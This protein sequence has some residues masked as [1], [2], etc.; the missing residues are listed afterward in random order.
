MMVWLSDLCGGKFPIGISSQ[1]EVPEVYRSA[2]AT[3]STT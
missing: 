1:E 3:L 2:V